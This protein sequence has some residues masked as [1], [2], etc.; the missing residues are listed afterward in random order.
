MLYVSFLWWGCGSKV[1]LQNNTCGQLQGVLADVA[2]S[3]NPLVAAQQKSLLANDSH[4]RVMVTLKEGTEVFWNSPI[5]TEL[6]IRFRHQ[7]LIP[8]D[9][10]CAFVS[11]QRVLS[12]ALPQKVSPK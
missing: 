7:I 1:P 8:P 6:S 2:Q 12:V 10:L 4:I 9:Q 11:D 3:S 5:Q